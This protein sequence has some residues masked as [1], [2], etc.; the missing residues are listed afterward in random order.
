MPPAIAA[1]WQGG[2]TL[3]LSGLELRRS[4]LPFAVLRCQGIYISQIDRGTL[5]PARAL[6][7]LRLEVRPLAK[8]RGGR[9]GHPH[10]LAP[11]A[12]QQSRACK[13]DHHD[14]GDDD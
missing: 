3:S 6:R 14:I 5:F 12:R 4:L 9:I 8:E 10:F 11:A 13:D 1:P 2:G 7:E